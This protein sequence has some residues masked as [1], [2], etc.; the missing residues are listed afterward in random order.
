MNLPTFRYHPDPIATG[1]IK[2]SGASCICCA[3]AR[4]FVYA[5]PVYS[6]R[7]NLDDAICPWCIAD[8]SAAKKFDASFTDAAGI[9]GGDEDWPEVSAGI[10]EEVSLRT[11]GYNSWQEER[12]FTCCDDAAAYL[13]A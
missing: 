12:W 13:G 6:T 4:G 9:G 10:I 2:P 11:P 3:E 7:N 5:G 8:G 1:S